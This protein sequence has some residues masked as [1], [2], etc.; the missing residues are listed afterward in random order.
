MS[1]CLF[2]TARHIIRH[3]TLKN[4]S[5]LGLAILAK[6]VVLFLIGYF[7]MG[8][9]KFSWH[10]LISLSDLLLTVVALA[11]M[12][13]AVITLYDNFI[14][15]AH[16]G[17][18][19][20]LIYGIDQSSI[21]TEKRLKTEDT[22]NVVGFYEFGKKYHSY[23]LSDLPVYYFNDEQDFDYIVGKYN[24]F[25]ILFTESKDILTEQN[26]L[27]KYCEGKGI[28]TLFAPPLTV[29]G[30]KDKKENNIRNVQIE[31]LLGREEISIDMSAIIKEADDKIVLVT[32][33]AGSIG[34]E[35]CRQLSTLTIRQLIVF[36]TAETPMHNLVLEFGT[37]YPWVNIVSIIGDVRN[38]NRL[39][40][41]FRTYT[42][43]VVFHAAAYKHVPMMEENP[44]EAISTNVFGTRNVADLARKYNV[45]KMIM[46]ST[47]KAVNPTNIMGGSKRLAEVYVQSLGTAIAHGTVKGSTQYVTT[48]FGNVLG[49]NGSVIPLFRKQIEEGGPVTVTHPNI[50]RYF[51]TIPEA[52]KLVLQATN[53][54]K[55]NDIF[56]FDMGEPVKI[57]DLAEKMITLSGHTPGKDIEIKFTSLRKGEKLYEELLNDGET[58]IDTPHKKIKMAKVREF[59]YD[60]V[61]E[62]LD[63]LKEAVKKDCSAEVLPLMMELV[64]E[65]IINQETNITQ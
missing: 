61:V 18:K 25:G 64:P 34:S 39:E 19:R 27:L 54:S 48:R 45:W 53:L 2:R 36:D 23:K 49:S 40:N 35:L 52:C 21:A 42:P 46:I 15:S 51:M 24:I 32:G 29:V 3:S 14:H 41:V 11:G 9:T 16:A 13:I 7:I 44:C 59:E 10:L 55:G 33:A 43:D 22:Y 20:L 62:V 30:V 6:T 31:D 28:K 63:R 60:H 65:Y 57:Y 56:V 1:F 38:K 58:T 8:V 26:R 47:D 5:T 4:I 50:I 37:K 12:R 17:T